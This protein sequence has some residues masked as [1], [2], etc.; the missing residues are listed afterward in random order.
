MKKY[1]I[2]FLGMG[3]IFTKHIKALKENKNFSVFG[4]YDKKKIDLNL[5]KD[6]LNIF[7]SEANDIVALLTPSGDH[8][9]QTKKALSF[10][11]HVVVEK[12]LALKLSH[13]KEIIGLEKKFKKKVFVV[14]QHRLNPGVNEI[15]QTI[16]KK[17]GKVF[18]ISSRLYWSRD[19]QYYK[20]GKW[21]GTWKHDGGVTT[22]QGIHTLDLI[23]NLFGDFQSVY[24]RA[25][26]ISKHVEAEDLSVVSLKFK[27]GE[28]CNMEFTTAVKPSNIENSIT[29]LGSKGFLKLSGKNFNEYSSSFTKNIKKID[30]SELHKKFYKEIYRSINKNKKNLFSAQSCV[31]SHE[32][33][34]AIYQSIKYKKEIMFPINTKLNINLGN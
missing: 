32:L 5:L 20:K 30:T 15:R 26:K 25:S 10:K 21:R 2:G 22:N 9:K 16:K 13:I 8:F 33:L 1:K 24:A 7:K 14:F 3:N 11:K 31:K 29:I 28:I 12:P 23:S 6:E 27:S 18:L 4:A 34:T 19:E 17:L